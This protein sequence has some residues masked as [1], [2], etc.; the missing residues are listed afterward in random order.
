MNATRLYDAWRRRAD[1]ENAFSVALEIWLQKKY[2]STLDPNWVV[3]IDG[4]IICDHELI[5]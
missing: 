4:S 2:P 3:L 1:S 5:M